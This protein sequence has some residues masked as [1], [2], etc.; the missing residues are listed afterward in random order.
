[1]LILMHDCFKAKSNYHRKLIETVGIANTYLVLQS[2][3]GE[4]PFIIFFKNSV[5]L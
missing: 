4:I 3:H 1:M 2:L 5:F